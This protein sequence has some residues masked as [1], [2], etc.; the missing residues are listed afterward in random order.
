MKCDKIMET[1]HK[2]V[3]DRKKY[4]VKC[5][6]SVTLALTCNKFFT[7]NAGTSTAEGG[8][9]LCGCWE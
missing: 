6:E 3:C 7:Y 9:A 4:V 1:S 5:N 8:M 2:I